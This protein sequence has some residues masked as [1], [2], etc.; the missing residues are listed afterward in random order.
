MAFI[1]KQSVS[2]VLVDTGYAFLTKA[3]MVN[4]GIELAKDLNVRVVRVG[5]RLALCAERRY[6]DFSVMFAEAEVITDYSEFDHKKNVELLKGA[7]KPACYKTLQAAV[8]ATEG[9]EIYYIGN[10]S[11][12]GKFDNRTYR[13]KLNGV[14]IAIF[15][16]GGYN[17]AMA[18]KIGK[19]ISAVRLARGADTISLLTQ[20][21][22]PP[23]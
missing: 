20:D 2:R 18:C 1:T 17:K 19:L 8:D 13:V 7:N 22:F 9:M 23:A 6:H 16:S 4:F 10:V 14:Q 12:C 15:E 11:G 21:E 3:H 5:E